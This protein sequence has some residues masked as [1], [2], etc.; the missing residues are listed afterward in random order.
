MLAE[1]K[2]K[3]F[4]Q[5]NT[6]MLRIWQIGAVLMKQANYNLFQW[7]ITVFSKT[8]FIFKINSKFFIIFLGPA[9]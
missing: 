1:I 8:K 2:V 5:E 7:R 4:D 3:Y 6:K 9:V